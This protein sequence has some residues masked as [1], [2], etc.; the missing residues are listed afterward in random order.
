MTVTAGRA[1]MERS[2]L[3]HR[4]AALAKV[5]E[6]GPGRID[7]ELLA[8]SGRLLLRAGDRLKLSGEH[9]VVALAGGTGSGKSSL[10]NRISG[11]ELSPTGV[12]RPTT[13]RPHACVWGIDGAG[14]L[15]DWLQ[16][17]WR[18]RFA[19]A[20]ALDKG[21]S[22]L[23]GLI[24]LDLPDHDS[25]RAI[26]DHEADRLIQVADVIVWVL[27]PQ[28]YADA[29]T[30]GKYVAELAGHEAVT[31][32][33]L[34]QA[35]RL[36]P[37]ELAE[38]VV[39]LSDLL[40]RE[41]VQHPRIVPTSAVTGRGVN[42]LKSV[43]ADSVAGRRAAVERLEADLDRVMAR[44]GKV[45]P[46]PEAMAVQS[47]VDLARQEGLTDALSDAVGVPAVGEAMENVYG[48]RSLDWIGWPFA[49]WAARLRPDPLNSLR[50]GN[51]KDEIKAVTAASVSAQPAE[52]ENAVQALADGLTSGMPEAWRNGVRDA[53]RSQLHRLPKVLSEE[54]A[55]AAPRLD[56]VPGWWRLTR[57][58]QYL[59]VAL[60][61]AGLAWAAAILVYGVFKLGR[62][63][64]ETLGDVALLP[65]IGV[66]LVSVLG[67]GLLSAVAGRNFVVLGAG[68]E[69]ERLE[70]EMRRRTAA[71]SKEMVIKPV[72]QELTRYNEFFAALSSV[73]R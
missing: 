13:A 32:F 35:D 61:A 31:V 49:R 24:L 44:L 30:H 70:R 71:V 26:T 18:H 68:N 37:E 52:V 34:N 58:W 55:E 36:A 38:C 23:H 10:F 8:E 29:A 60:F 28:K 42:S 25:I 73:R 45:M 7:P 21:E 59:L 33:A 67:L 41:G 72:E 12:R 14:P 40:K 48:V 54:L 65:W 57:I 16:I 51:L 43:L 22:Q 53:A 1:G 4:L 50:L 66:M 9:T 2:D 17:Q 15:L 39:D 47:T 69:R 56:R 27:D 46:E 5:V 63:P 20:S 62:A 64:S 11:L 6:L 3:G 19:R